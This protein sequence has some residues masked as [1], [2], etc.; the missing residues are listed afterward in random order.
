MLQILVTTY[1]IKLIVFPYY[2]GHWKSN[3]TLIIF[4]LFIRGPQNQPFKR[5]VL[6]K[7]FFIFSIRFVINTV[8]RFLIF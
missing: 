7:F 3:K 4:S 2:R 1:N 5:G 6:F 8:N